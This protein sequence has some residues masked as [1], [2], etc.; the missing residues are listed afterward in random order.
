MCMA[1]RYERQTI[2]TQYLRW[3]LGRW[4]FFLPAQLS[5]SVRT[6]TI[7]YEINKLHRVRART[8]SRKLKHAYKPCQRQDGR[9]SM[10]SESMSSQSACE[11]TS[12]NVLKDL[13][14]SLLLARMPHPARARRSLAHRLRTT[15]GLRHSFSRTRSFDPIIWTLTPYNS[16]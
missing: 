10:Q 6:W 8:Q 1:Y 12:M 5:A 15:L 14:E 16:H 13:A 4:E 2:R 7:W 3:L 9:T 11:R